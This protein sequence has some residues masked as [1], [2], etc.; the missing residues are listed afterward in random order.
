M[1]KLVD[2]E[3]GDVAEITV[4]APR[5]GPRKVINIQKAGPEV[6]DDE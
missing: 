3:A 6:L 2:L 1:F 4:Y 5:D